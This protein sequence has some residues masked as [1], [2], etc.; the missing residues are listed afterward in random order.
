MR[1][2]MR[3]TILFV[4]GLAF[5]SFMSCNK[6]ETTSVVQSGL[7]VEDFEAT[8]LNAYPIMGYLETGSPN[9]PLLD[10]DGNDAIWGLTMPFDVATE[11]DAGA[12]PTVT[13]KALYDNY[14][15]FILATWEDTSKSEQK[16]FWWLGKPNSGDTTY[17]DPKIEY[18]WNRISEPF[19]N[20]LG[21]VDKI[22]IDTTVVPA[23]TQIIYEYNKIEF[24]GDEDG[25][26]FMF[27]VNATNFLNCTNMCHGGSMQTDTDENVDI[28]YWHANLSNPKKYADDL[29][30]NADGISGDKGDAV[31]KEN[32][33]D[34]GPGFATPQDP[35]ANVPVLYDSVAVP[36]YST[37]PW[38]GGNRIPGYIIQ[39]P[40]GERA[41]IQAVGK[42]DGSKWT[43]E[44]RRPLNTLI[45]DDKTDIIINPDTDA[46][47]EFH[48]AVYNNSHGAGHAISTGVQLMHFLQYNQ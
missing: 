7:S 4:F 12:G 20:Y 47:L 31:F 5:L 14:Y 11:T 9:A 28:W 37:L 32:I 40:T 6:K 44:I 10:G 38:V 21:T 33:K 27:N 18:S 29:N 42:H 2:Y 26:A 46:N 34:D 16:D 13:L 41:D 30:M 25:L 23:D 8:S 17:A 43:V 45:E 48:L 36:Y 3:I 15:V 1:R 24:S 35:G 22:K 39:N 19:Y